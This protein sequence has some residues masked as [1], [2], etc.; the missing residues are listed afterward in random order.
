M[1]S[2]MMRR[3]REYFQPHYTL[4][5]FIEEY[6]PQDNHELERLEK[7]WERMC[8]NRQWWY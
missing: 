5:E 1:L 4:Q 7:I 3:L 6:K 8:G 2:D